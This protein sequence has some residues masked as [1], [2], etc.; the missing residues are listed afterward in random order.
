MMFI[1]AIVMSGTKEKLREILA[2]SN[3]TLVSNWVQLAS[4]IKNYENLDWKA[5]KKQALDLLK[6]GNALDYVEVVR[7]EQSKPKSTKQKVNRSKPKKSSKTKTKA[8]VVPLNTKRDRFSMNYKYLVKLIPDLIERLKNGEKIYG[9][10]KLTGYMD[11][12]IEFIHKDSTGYYL[13]MS[14]YYESGGDLIADPDM[15]IL[16]DTRNQTV[17]ALEFQ[18]GMYYRKVYDDTYKRRLVDDSEKKSQNAFLNQWLKNLIK[19]GHEVKWKHLEKEARSDS[20]KSNEKEKTPQSKEE[21]NSARFEKPDIAYM[22]DSV[23]ATSKSFV[24]KMPMEKVG[25]EYIS[26]VKGSKEYRPIVIYFMVDRINN[27]GF[28]FEVPYPSA[29]VLRS[30]YENLVEFH[31]KNAKLDALLDGV[32]PSTGEKSKDKEKAA[33]DFELNYKKLLQVIPGLSIKMNG[34]RIKPEKGRVFRAKSKK[35]GLIYDLEAKLSYRDGYEA[36]LLLMEKDEN[37]EIL[38]EMRLYVNNE[39][40]EVLAL[41]TRL[42]NSKPVYVYSN[43]KKFSGADKTQLKEQNE[44]LGKWLDEL[45]RKEHKITKWK[46]QEAENKKLESEVLDE[47]SKEDQSTKNEAPNETEQEKTAKHWAKLAAFIE[48]KEGLSKEEA[49][50]KAIKL[51]RENEAVDYVERNFNRQVKVNQNNLLK[52]NYQRLLRLIPQLFSLESNQSLTLVNGKSEHAILIDSY[53][54]R[55]KFSYKFQLRQGNNIE[56][57]IVWNIDV[58]KT[59]KKVK[60]EAYYVGDEEF[61]SDNL[62]YDFGKWLDQQLDRNLKSNESQAKR[63]L[64]KFP[65]A[66]QWL[67]PSSSSGFIEGFNSLEELRDKFKEFILPPYDK[68]QTIAK[69]WFNDM[70]R[71]ISIDISETEGDFNPKS[72]KYTLVDWLEWTQTETD[73]ARFS[74]TNVK[75]LP[76][77][78][79][80]KVANKDRESSLDRARKSHPIVLE[81][82]EGSKT[83]RNVGFASLEDL[84]ERLRTYDLK[85]NADGYL[86]TYVWF[87]GY[88]NQVRIDLSKTK[89][90]FDPNNSSY[91]LEDWLEKL[92]PNFDW[93]KFSNET[94]P[95]KLQKKADK[96]PKMEV[97]KVKLTKE[98]KRAGLTQKHIN[99]INKHKQGIV[100]TPSKKMIN[101]TKS[102]ASDV[103]KQALPAG[104]RVSKTGRIYYETRSNRSD[105][106]KAGL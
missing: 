31:D 9:K 105:I 96:V 26:T 69:I 94:D 45:L 72:R 67:A 11:F 53:G 46:K 33:F 81:M 21:S 82:S 28:G 59:G 4:L 14:H 66:M 5:S 32:E 95:K 55:G 41:S 90:N 18:N 64:K 3:E 74:G 92:D 58:Q 51:K 29:E 100:I 78:S 93:F 35:K 71:A 20:P 12:N 49:K 65:I 43:E 87:K 27:G 1:K 39:A 36:T 56:S 77:K 60:V 8:K 22:D 91:D 25:I 63:I 88:P 99:W 79:K 48:K 16:V 37:G 106:T 98:H 68:V 83:D 104:K 57:E 61:K 75:E 44:F 84:H 2:H 13:A 54:K 10:S 47:Y 50:E 7:S 103:T 42:E 38:T 23:I 62:D 40:K 73:W 19:Q 89:G 15:K 80:P 17:Q 85:S 101:N 30:D 24:E 70:D 76:S 52:T 6:E 86:K 34:I 102:F 97:G